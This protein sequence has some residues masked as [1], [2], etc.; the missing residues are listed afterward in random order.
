MPWRG[1][2]DPYKV[3]I[4]EIML[5]QTTVAAVVP[6][7]QRFMTRFPDLSAL[8]AADVQDVLSAWEGL[9]YYSRGRNLHRAAQVVMREHGGRFPRDVENLRTLPGIGRYTAGAI[10]SFAFDEPAPI[11]EANT[12]RVYARL[13]D[14]GLDPRSTEGQAALWGFAQSIVPSKGAGAFNQALIDLGALVCVPVN[15]RCDECPLAG[16]CRAFRAGRQNEIPPPKTRPK[17]TEVHEAVMAIRRDGRWLVRQRQPGERWAGMWDFP[18]IPLN[19]PVKSANAA[20]AKLHSALFESTG[21]A[22]DLVTA[23]SGFSHSVTRYRIHLARFVV[24]HAAGEWSQEAAGR[25]VTL[26]ELAELPVP[27]ALRRFVTD[28]EKPGWDPQAPFELVGRP[29]PRKK[30][31][32]RPA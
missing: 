29:H 10:A 6:Y 9:G 4:S 19:G 18:R 22:T 5:Q 24:D 1:V 16:L 27:M 14:Y 2:A 15:P 30:K 31:V 26:E 8:A 17:V 12:Q 21:L 13:S 7:Y 3:W 28:L 25:W 32:S 11:L 20:F 23:L